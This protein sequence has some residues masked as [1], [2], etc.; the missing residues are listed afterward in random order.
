MVERLG[1]SLE[2]SVI[3]GAIAF[4]VNEWSLR[5]DYRAENLLNRLIR[6][7]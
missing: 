6:P 5:E 1:S 7:S 4:T 2:K 3:R